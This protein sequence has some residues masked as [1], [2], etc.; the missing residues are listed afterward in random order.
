MIIYSKPGATTFRSVHLPEIGRDYWYASP[1]VIEAQ[2]IPTS[3]VSAGVFRQVVPQAVSSIVRT[4]SIVLDKTKT[5]SLLAMQADTT[6]TSYYVNIGTAVFECIVSVDA[7]PITVKKAQVNLTF[8]VM[9]Q[10]S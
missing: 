5:D 6:Q 1:I 9:N 2:T 3:T 8:R 4:Y 10:I 7:R